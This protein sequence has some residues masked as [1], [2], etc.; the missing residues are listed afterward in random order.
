MTRLE[1]LPERDQRAVRA[2]LARKSTKRDAKPRASRAGQ[3]AGEHASGPVRCMDCPDDHRG[4]WPSYTAWTK[5]A[6]TSGHHHVRVVEASP[7][8]PPA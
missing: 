2:A 5:H 3:A 1:D 6:D 8:T 4:I 7:V